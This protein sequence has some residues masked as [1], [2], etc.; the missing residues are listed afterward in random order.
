VDYYAMVAC[1]AGVQHGER[2]LRGTDEDRRKRDADALRPRLVEI[3]TTLESIAP[4]ARPDAITP[5]RA[6][7]NSR[8]NIERLTPVLKKFVRF[9]AAE[10]NNGAEPCLDEIELWTAA[11]QPRNVAPGARASS[12]GNYAGDPKH[13]LTHINDGQYGNGRSWISNTPGRGWIELELPN[14]EKIALIVWGRDREDRYKDRLAI[15]YSVEISEDG[16]NWRAVANSNDREPFKNVLMPRA[17][18]E[19]S[20]LDPD[21]E[22]R[23]AKLEVE[24]HE[25]ESKISAL[26]ATPRAYAGRFE[27]PM[28]THRFHRGDPMQLREEIAPAALAKFGSKV[29]ITIDAPEQQRRVALANWIADRAHPLTARVLVNRLWQHHFGSGLVETPS[30]FGLN[31]A[32]PTHPELLD[33][34][35]TEFISKKWSVKAMQRLIVMSA[36]YRQASTANEN[37]RK[38]DADAHL[39][40]RIPPQRL[41][42]EPLRDAILAVTGKLDLKMGGA[43]FDLF[44]PN[45]NYVKVYNPRRDFEADTF[46]RMIYWAKPRMQLDD[47]FGNFDCPDG[48]QIAPKRNR[49]TT[50]LQALA[51]LNSPFLDQQATFLAERLQ[52]D[53]GPD[54]TAQ[55]CRAFALAFSREASADETDAAVQLIATHGLPAF[56]RAILNASE[57]VTVF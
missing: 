13:Q 26:T 49:S 57:F 1:V 56:C 9:T 16:T 27:Q 15:R 8:R 2:D 33:W 20:T 43:G 38:L 24:R 55:V 37:A 36:T 30:D 22:V 21:Q 46:R 19:S 25:I 28:P 5:R 12:S 48:G 18:W 41:E 34:L 23:A 6:P 53:A 29:A 31:G 52:H 14:P 42:A 45:T 35:A 39:L 54:K 47:T 11:A 10:T 44:D 3:T 51:L 17:E 7:V 32:R 40:W 4:I 50:P